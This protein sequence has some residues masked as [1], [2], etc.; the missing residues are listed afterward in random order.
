ML[1]ILHNVLYSAEHLAKNNTEYSYSAEP[2]KF[3]F[4]LTVIF[5]YLYIK[6]WIANSNDHASPKQIGEAHVLAARPRT[7]AVASPT[8]EN[9]HR[10]S[11]PATPRPPFLPPD[12]LI[13]H[14]VAD[15]AVFLEIAGSDF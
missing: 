1:G 2:Q 12:R 15:V 11:P 5:L 7:R 14:L 6:R 4:G 3:R 9:L 13:S 10:G 8:R